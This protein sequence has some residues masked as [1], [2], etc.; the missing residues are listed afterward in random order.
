VAINAHSS[1]GAKDGAA[2]VLLEIPLGA[3]EKSPAVDRGS[4]A[5]LPLTPTASF[6]AGCPLLRYPSE[7]V[8]VTGTGYQG[9]LLLYESAA[10]NF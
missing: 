1:D 2:G 3:G 6:G 5:S 8:G 10:Y 7:G 9:S 4:F